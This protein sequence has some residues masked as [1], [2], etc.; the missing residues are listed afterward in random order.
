LLAEVQEIFK[1]VKNIGHA[2]G[3]AKNN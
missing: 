2:E 3:L 1:P